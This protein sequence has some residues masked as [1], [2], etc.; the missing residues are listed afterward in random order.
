[1]VMNGPIAAVKRYTGK[2]YGDAVKAC[3]SWDCD[4]YWQKQED[5]QQQ[6]L[7]NFPSPV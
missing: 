1:M 3:L 5:D 6:L 2:R 7:G 4:A